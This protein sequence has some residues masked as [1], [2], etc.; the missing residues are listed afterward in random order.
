M[1]NP[2]RRRVGRLEVRHLRTRLGRVIDIGPGGMRLR[3]RPWPPLHTYGP[4]QVELVGMPEVLPITVA[5]AWQ[6]RPGPLTREIGLAFV[7]LNDHA[8]H[9]LAGLFAACRDV[10]PRRGL[11]TMPLPTPDAQG[12][13]GAAGLMP[14]GARWRTIAWPTSP[15]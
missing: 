11:L 9:V 8:R 2:Q 13:A 7:E 5:L 14:P 4:F 6:T 15:R 12:Q 10:T 3:G 1:P